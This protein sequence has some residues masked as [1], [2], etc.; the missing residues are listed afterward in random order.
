MIAALTVAGC[1][2]LCLA[3]EEP[4]S[5][6]TA[7]STGSSPGGTEDRPVSTGYR[8]EVRVDLVQLNFLATDRKGNPVTDLKAEEVEILDGRKRQ[9]I[10]FLQHYYTPRK[11]APEA[12]GPPAEKPTAPAPGPE[13]S[14]ADRAVTP[15]RWIVLFIDNYV[16]SPRTRLKAID[17]ARE[18]VSNEVRDGDQVAVV[19]FSGKLDLLQGF[20]DDRIVLSG[21]CDRAM[22]FTERAT[23]DRF[24]AIEEL[25]QMLE[26]CRNAGDGGACAERHGHSYEDARKREADAFLTALILLTRAL[27]PIPDVKTLVLFSEGFS[28]IPSQDAFEAA[29]A[30]LGFGTARMLPFGPDPRTEMSYDRLAEAA[31]AAKV[32][33]FTINPGGASRHSAISARRRYP[34][35]G[36]TNPEAVDVHRRSEQNYQQGLVEL[37]RRTGGTANQTSDVLEGLRSAVDVARGLYT[38]GYYPTE[39]LTGSRMHEVKIRIRRRGVKVQTRREVPVPRLLPPLTGELSAEPRECNE[40]GRRMLL[41]NLRL[42]RN[43]LTFEKTG[44]RYASN[45]SLY[46]RFYPENAIEPL[47]QDYHFFNITNTKDEMAAGQHP[48]PQYE[49]TLIVPCRPLTV[50]VTATDAASGAR[51]DFT[52]RVSD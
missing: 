26:T 27:A 7:G 17:A 12:S 37:A 13:D 48:D 8:E 33:I 46:V 41:V 10:A 6:K 19:S 14:R 1:L 22:S 38:V 31:A 16:S 45:F 47:F 42:D 39:D 5:A 44:K 20:T 51:G 2:P 9:E 50:M 35:G 3:A 24:G 36:A 28:R 32:S 34:I 11:A 30:V 52:A 43:R 23:D 4:D 15:G 21:A 40:R 18:F 25:M 49:R 29:T